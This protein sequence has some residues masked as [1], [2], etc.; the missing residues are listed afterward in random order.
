MI[1]DKGCKCDTCIHVDHPEQCGYTKTV[2]SEINLQQ[3]LSAAQAELSA[4]RKQCGEVAD[5][6]ESLI[7]GNLPICK[8]DR[9]IV[10]IFCPAGSADICYLCDFPDH[11]KILR[12]MAGG[13]Q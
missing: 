9:T 8:E 7:C 13:A 12:A 1:G 3:Q 5:E 6:L 2:Q 11:I 10:G 4:L